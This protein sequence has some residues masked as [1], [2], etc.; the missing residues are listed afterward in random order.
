MSD[1][2]QKSAG[3][4]LQN[5]QGWHD[6]ENQFDKAKVYQE[7]DEVRQEIQKCPDC[8]GDGWVWA[9][10]TGLETKECETCEGRGRLE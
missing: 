4:F 10:P 2:K 8:D 9:S 3:A 5:R 1:K 6:Y 7:A